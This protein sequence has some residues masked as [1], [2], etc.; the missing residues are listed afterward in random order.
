MRIHDKVKGAGGVLQPHEITESF[1]E[2]FPD[3]D[4]AVKVLAVMDENPDH[5]ANRWY[6]W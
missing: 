5:A 1:A 4:I 2:P 3:G 6:N